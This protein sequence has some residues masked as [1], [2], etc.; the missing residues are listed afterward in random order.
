VDDNVNP[1]H[2][3]AGLSYGYMQVSKAFNQVQKMV[4]LLAVTQ[5]NIYHLKKATT[6]NKTKRED[7]QK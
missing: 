6:Q 2:K 7:E 3:N 4:K 5:I 1:D